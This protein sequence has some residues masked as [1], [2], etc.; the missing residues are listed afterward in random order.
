MIV[1]ER[2]MTNIIIENKDILGL[3]RDILGIRSGIFELVFNL[4]FIYV[5]DLT[6]AVET[7]LIGLLPS[8]L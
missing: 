8:C 7:V 5:H 6:N 3:T 1:E 4:I 2:V